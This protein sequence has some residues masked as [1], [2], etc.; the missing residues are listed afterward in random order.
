MQCVF[1]IAVSAPPKDNKS[2]MRSVSK[3]ISK[4][5]KSAFSKQGLGEWKERAI[6]TLDCQ[7]FSCSKCT[8]IYSWLMMITCL[9]H[10]MSTKVSLL[11]G[12]KTALAKALAKARSLSAQYKGDI[13]SNAGD[14]LEISFEA[15]HNAM[16]TALEFQVKL[17]LL[18]QTQAQN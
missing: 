15:P 6:L 16:N 7:V 13:F 8:S 12:Y 10:Q 11:P 18:Y 9:C 1:G 17:F 3:N 2:L 4:A 5:A 14:A